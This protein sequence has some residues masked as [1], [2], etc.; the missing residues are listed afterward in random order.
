MKH[1]I[2]IISINIS[3]LFVLIELI[4]FI[5]MK[6]NT[7]PD[8]LPPNIILNAHEKYGHWHPVNSK[9]KIAT[10]CWKSEVEFNNLGLKNTKD[11]DFQKTK[12]RIA[13]LGDSMTENAQLDNNK[14]FKF[15]LQKLLPEFEVIN[16]SVSSI[17]LA[18]HIKIY[19]KLVSKF[20]VDYVF[21]YL[22]YNDFSD[23]HISKSR[24]S[25]ISYKVENNKIEKIV[26]DTEGYFKD[27]NSKWNLFKREKLI[28]VKKY[29]NSYKL[30][31][32]IKQKIIGY[33]VQKKVI[34]KKVIDDFFD[35]KKKY[36][37]F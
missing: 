12:K 19:D 34:K 35:D 4:S 29:S 5:L 9:F 31:W 28:Y 6:T 33:E 24:P 14:D 17:G 23:N 2:K 25:R 21:V 10:K 18:D 20:N 32:F 8:G 16:F 27:Y 22:T 36:S 11:I 7:I 26:K 37:N 15:K 3:F 1:F 13:I 30:Y